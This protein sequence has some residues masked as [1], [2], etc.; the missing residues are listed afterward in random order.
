MEPIAAAEARAVA[1]LSRQLDIALAQV[2]LTPA[3]YRILALLSEGSAA[4]TAL[5]RRLAVSRPSITALVD[6]LVARGLV[7][8]GADPD[9][10][11]RVTHV[12]TAQGR[13]EL[14]R[15]DAAATA[16]LGEI[17]RHTTADDVAAARAGLQAWQR[18]LDAYR[19]TKVAAL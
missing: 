12:L 3:Q 4:A 5:A 2:D 11:R 8:R 13:R 10:R 19:E 7:E 15:A 9:D 1:R 17:A 16:R 18:A 14:E 6:G